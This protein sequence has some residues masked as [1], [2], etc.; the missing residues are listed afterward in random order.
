MGTTNLFSMQLWFTD[1]LRPAP[2]G[3]RAAQ[4]RK[5]FSN[6]RFFLNSPFNARRTGSQVSKLNNAEAEECEKELF[7]FCSALS[8]GY[9]I[10]SEQANLPPKRKYVWEP[11]FMVMSTPT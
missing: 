11:L 7:F 9:V 6:R 8:G 5:R 3:L 4:V 2:I 10:P 1:S